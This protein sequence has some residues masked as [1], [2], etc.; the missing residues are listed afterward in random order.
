MPFSILWSKVHY[1]TI[2]ENYI[3]CYKA[4]L[5]RYVLSKD[6]NCWT[7]LDFPNKMDEE[8][9]HNVGVATEN[10]CLQEMSTSPYKGNQVVMHH[11]IAADRRI[12]S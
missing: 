4:I 10:I 1:I 6:L 12:V 5:K 2:S 9:F 7:V 8:A 3:K 11:L